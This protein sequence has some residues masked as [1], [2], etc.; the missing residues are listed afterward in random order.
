MPQGKGEGYAI[1][2]MAIGKRLLKSQLVRGNGVTEEYATSD[3][4][5]RQRLNT[6]S[7]QAYT[8]NPI[9]Y[10]FHCSS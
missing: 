10:L 8:S 5:Q 9:N 7:P 4:Y 1:A 3:P 6:K 2:Q